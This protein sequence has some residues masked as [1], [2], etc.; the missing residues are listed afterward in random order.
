MHP[1]NH[2]P[3]AMAQVYANLEDEIAQFFSRTSTTREECDNFALTTFKG[4]VEPVVIQ[5]ATSYTVVAGQHREKIVQFR[6][7]DAQLDMGMLDLARQIH[8]DVVP[9]GSY[10]GCIGG[11]ERSE[12]RL[13]VYEMDRVPEDNYG[14]VR[15]SLADFPDRQLANIRS[16]ARFVGAL[17]SILT[18]FPRSYVTEADMIRKQI[19]RTELAQTDV[20]EPG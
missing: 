6:N 19:L 9:R 5:G 7:M 11:E 14:M 1:N 15:A 12:S 10:L 8:G 16:L 18:L 13:A 2:S 17:L 4:R 20:S 3:A